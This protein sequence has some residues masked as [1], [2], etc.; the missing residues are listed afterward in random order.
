MG[1][2]MKIKLSFY[3]FMEK[4]FGD[5]ADAIDADLHEELR[6]AMKDDIATRI[7]SEDDAVSKERIVK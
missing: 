1:E 6:T 7:L 2:R 4:L 5:L 3:R